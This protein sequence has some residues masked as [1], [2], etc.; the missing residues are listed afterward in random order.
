MVSAMPLVLKNAWI[1][2]CAMCTFALIVIPVVAQAQRAIY[3]EDLLQLPTVFAKGAIYRVD[4]QLI[5]GARPFRFTLL[6]AQLV[7]NVSDTDAIFEDDMLVIK[8][9]GV[10][11]VLHWAKLRL[12]DTEPVV[13][14]L[15]IA[16]IDDADDDNDGLE[17]TFDENPMT[18]ELCNHPLCMRE[19]SSTG[20]PV[21]DSLYKGYR[22]DPRAPTI[23][24][25]VRH[26]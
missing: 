19:P 22:E 10:A 14:E 1:A 5:R 4:L 24:L 2:L 8:S 17:D 3:S 23:D 18:P 26:F 20:L 15:F 9:V 13:F 16:G 21:R 12:V 25:G 7:E 11:G 6:N